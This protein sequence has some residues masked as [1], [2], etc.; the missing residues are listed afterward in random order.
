M[1]LA[2]AAVAVVLAGCAPAFDVAGRDWTRPNTS[3]P[4]VTL[5]ETSCT[6]EAY[7]AGWT[8]DLLLGGFLDLERIVIQNVAQIFAYDR[9]MTQRG[10]QPK[11][12]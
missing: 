5:D 9:C 3:V 2:M 8:P 7:D 1:R 12:G 4:Q 11:T 10:Y 6:R